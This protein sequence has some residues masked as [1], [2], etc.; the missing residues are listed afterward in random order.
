MSQNYQGKTYQEVQHNFALT[1][2]TGMDDPQAQR[3]AVVDYRNYLRDINRCDKKKLTDIER[4]DKETRAFMAVQ[5]Y[6]AYVKEKMGYQDNDSDESPNRTICIEKLT[7]LE[8]E[9]FKEIQLMLWEQIEKFVVSR[10]PKEIKNNKFEKDVLYQTMYVDFASKMIFRYKP[11]SPE[12]TSIVRPTTYFNDHIFKNAMTTYQS[13]KTSLTKHEL[14]KNG[15]IQRAINSMLSN[16]IVPTAEKIADLTDLSVGVVRAAL[17]NMENRKTISLDAKIKDDDGSENDNVKVPISKLPTPEEEVI[18]KDMDRILADMVNAELDDLERQVFFM[19]DDIWDER[20]IKHMPYKDIAEE[21]GLTEREVKRIHNS[22]RR[23]LSRSKRLGI[24]L[25]HVRPS[26]SK[27]DS[28]KVNSIMV[29]QMKSAI[30]DSLFPAEKI[31]DLMNKNKGFDENPA[32]ENEIQDSGKIQGENMNKNECE[33]QDGEEAHNGNDDKN[34]NENR[35]QNE[36][37]I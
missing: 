8:R 31:S 25:N 5:P 33:S 35:N 26:I 1:M 24:A 23:K 4:F 20:E 17:I 36:G 3:Q 14:D 6:L 21:L 30:E 37:D 28:R 11:Y 7:P 32:A 34:R 29:S 27:R 16:N 22:A 12:R 10:F 15:K 2:E 18:R 19:R 13:D 9:V